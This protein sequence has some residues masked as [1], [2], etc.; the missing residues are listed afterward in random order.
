[1]KP[2]VSMGCPH[3]C[4]EEDYL[5]QGGNTPFISI[6]GEMVD[7]SSMKEDRVP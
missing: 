6:E 1:M 3:A 7:S 2:G 5:E 4:L